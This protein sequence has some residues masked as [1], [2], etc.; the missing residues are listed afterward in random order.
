MRLRVHTK[1]A[2]WWRTRR[3]RWPRRI[4]R[5]RS[6]NK[7]NQKEFLTEAQ[8]PRRRLPSMFS[9]CSLRLCEK[10]VFDLPTKPSRGFARWSDSRGDP[11]V[12]SAKGDFTQRRRDRGEH[13]IYVLLPALCDSARDLF[14]T[15]PTKPSK[16]FARWSD[17]RRD[18]E[19][20][21]AKGD[22]TQRRRDRGEDCHRCF[23]RALCASVRNLFLIYPTMPSMVA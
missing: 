22:F 1:Y 2:W 7:F 11:E 6:R 15:Y 20:N 14:S 17:S 12:N 8:R 3:E 10:F 9:P 13:C 23:L 21:S 19:V 18:P 5:W 16:G 4:R